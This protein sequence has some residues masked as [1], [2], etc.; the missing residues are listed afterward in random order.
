MSTSPIPT[1]FKEQSEKERKGIT[2]E[3]ELE[4]RGDSLIFRHFR[5][6]QSLADSATSK[7]TCDVPNDP[8]ICG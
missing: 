1:L 3:L 2:K 7:I 6:L 8:G 5:K 4:K